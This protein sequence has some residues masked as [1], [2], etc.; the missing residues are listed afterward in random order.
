M[1]D[2]GKSTARLRET[3]GSCAFFTGEFRLPAESVVDNSDV[4]RKCVLTLS[5]DCLASDGMPVTRVAS[6]KLRKLVEEVFPAEPVS[7][8]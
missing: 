3:V 6:P 8:Q 5:G 1:C 2:D 4:V 7:G